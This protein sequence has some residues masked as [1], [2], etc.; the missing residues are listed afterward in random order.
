MKK[1]NSATVEDPYPKLDNAEEWGRTQF[2]CAH[3]P[4]N[5]LCSIQCPTLI[6]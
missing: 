5:F 6:I 4:L 1:V 2:V 3:M